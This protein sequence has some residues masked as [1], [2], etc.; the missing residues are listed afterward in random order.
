MNSGWV[1][2]QKVSLSAG[3]GASTAAWLCLAASA[4]EPAIV[5]TAEQVHGDTIATTRLDHSDTSGGGRIT[6]TGRV[7]MAERGPDPILAPADGRVV[8][9]YAH[10][11]EA[12]KQYAPI[13]ALAGPGT[14][15]LSRSLADA[16]TLSAAAKERL[17]RDEKL[18]AAGIVA[19]ARLQQSR[20]SADLAKGQLAS[21]RRLLGAAE[22]GPDGRLV[23]RAPRAGAVSGPPFGTGD[24][25][26]TGE[27]IA[28]VGAPQNPLIS[29]DAPVSS[30]RALRIGDR[31]QVSGRGC[32][33]TAV[34]HAIGRT[35]DPATQTVALHG[36]IMGS[37]CLLPGEVVTATVTPHELTRDTFA[38][39]S[40]AFVRRGNATYLF[41]QTTRGFVPVAV[42]A[43]A[44]RMGYA[45]APDLQ[46]GSQVVVR[47]AALLKAEWL[48]RGTI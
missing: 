46:T 39:P 6:L 10:P 13:L 28:Y 42:D 14:I 23:L 5:L 44:A 48:K 40:A 29:L 7:E 30:A 17:E 11:G 8:A 34:L 32:D 1:R 41:L 18:Y 16:E 35:V 3:V 22:F 21:N 33:Q 24:A 15:A 36:E 31:L 19:L 37:P 12:V 25:V 27:P 26:T 20:T 4:A 45:R 47:G 38:V 43:D 2:K 9:V